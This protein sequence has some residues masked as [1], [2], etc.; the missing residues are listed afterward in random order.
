MPPPHLPGTYGDE[1]QLVGLVGDYEEGLAHVAHAA[2]GGGGAA[3]GAGAEGR[4]LV[5]WL[6]SS[7]GNMGRPAAAQFLARL[8]A[9]ALRRGDGLLVGIDRRNAP[10]LVSAAYDDSKVGG[11]RHRGARGPAHAAQA[12]MGA[13][14]RGLQLAGSAA[15]SRAR[16]GHSWQGRTSCDE[17]RCPVPPG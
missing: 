17:Q 16:T 1:L 10:E 5:L 6:G 8:R 4:R 12:C 15:A 13:L 11:W 14:A 9:A 3:S 2:V 7:I